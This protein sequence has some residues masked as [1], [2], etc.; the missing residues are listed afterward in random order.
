MTYDQWKDPTEDTSE[1]ERLAAE[2]EAETQIEYASDL[3]GW[4]PD[5]EPLLS[6]LQR[7]KQ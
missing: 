6:P 5:N 3:D 7:A 4:E 2:H 1:D